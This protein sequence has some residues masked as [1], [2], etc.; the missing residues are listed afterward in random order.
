M[1]DGEREPTIQ[2]V[3]GHR[4]RLIP[5]IELYRLPPGTVVI[6]ERFYLDEHYR[7]KDT[8]YFRARVEEHKSVGGPYNALR[9]ECD[10]E[11]PDVPPWQMGWIV[12]GYY[13]NM[14]FWMIEED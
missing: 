8:R 2:R 4:L 3:N 13:E 14:D 7:V 11:W 1:R 9:S 5:S 10:W 12:A 6:A